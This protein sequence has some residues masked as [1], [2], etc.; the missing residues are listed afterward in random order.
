MPD[1]YAPVA[2]LPDVGLTFHELLASLRRQ[3]RLRPLVLEA[4]AEKAIL[5]AARETGLSVSA[6]ELQQAANRFRQQHG[7]RAAEDTH[8]WLQ[9]N[10]L[11]VIDLEARLE[12]AL[13]VEKFRN[14]LTDGRIQERCAAEAD[15]YAR[16]RI[17]YFTVPSEGLARELLA[18]IRDDGADFAEVAQQHARAD[19]AAAGTSVLVMRADL[20]AGMGDVVFQAR[21]DS[22]VGPVPGPQGWHLFHVH[23]LLPPQL[24]EPTM[25]RIRQ[26]LLDGWLRERIAQARVDLSGLDEP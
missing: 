18:R 11:R 15:R 5:Q 14:H 16:A 24:D 13:L 22:V 23:E 6:E 19:S 9:Q 12:Q 7:L 8:A 25:A 2:T 21:P 26:D 1:L 3:F 17:S 10:G 4:L 20:S